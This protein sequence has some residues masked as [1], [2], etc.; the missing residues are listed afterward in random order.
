MAAAPVTTAIP[1]PPSWALMLI[2]FAG[3][4]MGCYRVTQTGPLKER[5][6]KTH[7]RRI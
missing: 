5:K 1:E 3:L 6:S 7:P 4:A 2:G